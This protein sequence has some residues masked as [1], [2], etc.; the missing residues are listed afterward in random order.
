MYGI[1]NRA[2]EELVIANFRQEKWL[3]VKQRSAV[4][5]DFFISNEATMTRS[6]RLL[7]TAVSEEMNMPLSDAVMTAFGEWWIVET[8]K[9]KHGG[10]MDYIRPFLRRIL[11]NPRRFWQQGY[12]IYPKLVNRLEFKVTDVEA[13]SLQLHLFFEKELDLKIS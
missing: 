13:N 5:A 6:R 9:E 3:A 8:G 12:A 10:L 11:V 1:I 7:A 4:E 2:L